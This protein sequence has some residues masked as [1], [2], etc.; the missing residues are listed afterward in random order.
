MI[1]DKILKDWLQVSYE[2]AVQYGA[3]KNKSQFIVMAFCA[4]HSRFI[5]NIER[6]NEYA[7][8]LKQILL[9]I[10]TSDDCRSLFSKLTTQEQLVIAASGEFN[11][12]ISNYVEGYEDVTLDINLSGFRNDAVIRKSV[13]DKMKKLYPDE[14]FAE[15]FEDNCIWPSMKDDSRK[16]LEVIF[17]FLNT[18]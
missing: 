13:Q 10:L 6:T 7:Q 14:E 2:T 9:K 12:L 15:C 16:Y 18:P 4:F 3:I 8:Q 5:E 11:H 17:E 1:T